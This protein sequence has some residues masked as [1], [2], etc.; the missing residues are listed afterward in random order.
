MLRQVDIELKNNGLQPE[1]LLEKKIIQVYETMNVRFGMVLV[2][3]SGSG[4][5]TSIM[6]LKAALTSLKDQ[7]FEHP[8]YEHVSIDIINPKCITMGELYGENN[9]LTQVWIDGLASTIMRRNA[10]D[11]SLDKKWLVF[12]GPI[13]ALWIENMNTVLDD[14]MTLCLANGER[15]RLKPQMRM[16]FEVGDLDAASPATVSRLGVVYVSTE[17]VGWRPYV[18][19]WLNR[20]FKEITDKEKERI[21]WNCDTFFP[22]LFQLIRTQLHEP[23]TTQDQNLV[24]SFCALFETVYKPFV[25]VKPGSEDD[26]ERI[27]EEKTTQLNLFIDQ[28]CSYSIL[29]SFGCSIDPE[30]WP[31]FD[32]LYHDLL[33]EEQLDIGYASGLCYDYLLN[34]EKM[35]FKDWNTIVPKFVYS[36][37][38][39]F[40]QLV[41]PTV[42]T[43]RFSYLL[44]E[45]IK[46]GKAVF[47][48]GVTGTGKTVI[49]ESTLDQLKMPIEEGGHLF[50]PIQLTFSARTS[51]YVT[52]NTIENSLQK[53]RKNLLGPTAPSHHAIISIDDI[54]MPAVEKYGAQ[55][56]I[57]LIRQFITYKGF[58]DR[59]QLFWKDIINT[60]LVAAAAPPGGGRNHITQRLT[61][62]FNIFSLPQASIESL[63]LIFS[64]IVNG[65][66]TNFLAEVKGLSNA[67]VNSTIDIYFK[68]IGNLRPTPAKFHYTFNLRDVSK[69]IQGLLMI[70]SKYCS[71]AETMTRL[72]VHESLRVFHDRLISN[73]DKNWFKDNV[74]QLLSRYFHFSTNM[75]D[76][77][78]TNTI[79]FGDYMKIGVDFTEKKYEEITDIGKVTRVFQDY[80]D[81]YNLDNSTQLNLVFF[82]DA[83]D[84]ISRI[85][86]ILRQPRGNAMLV[87]VGGSGKQSLTRLSCF[88][89]GL[90]CYQ[91]EITRGYNLE[92]FRENLKE[93]MVSTGVNGERTVFLFT[94]S[95]IMQETF[96]ED[97]NSILNSGEVP[98][99]FETDEMEK[100]LN[101]MVPVLKA[102]NLPQSRDMCKLKFVERIRDCL[103]V[104]LCMSPVGD[105]LRIRCRQF[106]S[107]INCC[108]ID[109]YLPWPEDALKSVAEH[110]FKEMESIDQ[111]VTPSL[112][113]SCVMVHTSINSISID[114]FNELRRHVYTT[115]KSYLDLISLYQLLLE[116][117]KTELSNKLNILEMGVTKLKD[118][119][120]VVEGLRGEL[121][122]LQPILVEKSKASDEL[123]E[124][125]SKEAGEAEEIKEKVEAETQIVQKQQEEV[126]E[127][128]SRAQEALDV[129]LP[130]L[131]E[132]KRALD[133]LDKKDIAEIKAFKTPPP[134]VQTVMEAV[135]ILLD[136]KADWDSAKKV[137]S[138]TDFIK[139]LQQYDKDNIPAKILQKLHKYIENP[140]MSPDNVK[141]ISFA[142]FSLC[143]W[144]HAISLYA[145]VFKDVEPLRNEVARMNEELKVANDQLAE[146]KDKLSEI[147]G[148][149]EELQRQSDEVNAEKQ[150]ISEDIEITTKRLER[151]E[152][153]TKGLNAEGIRWSEQA[154]DYKEQIRLLIGDVFISSACISYY[155]PFTGIYRDRIVKN[156]IEKLRELKLPLSSDYSIVKTLGDPL[157]IQEWQINGLPTDSVS[158][159]NSLLTTKGKRWPLLID[160]QGQAN[161]WIR[162]NNSKNLT[163]TKLHDQNLLRTLENCIRVGRILLI[164]DIGETLIASLE[165]ILTK[166]IHKQGGRYLIHLGDS[167][168]DY[169]QNFQLFI[170]TKLPNPHYLP[171]VYI[172]VN[173]INFTVT[174]EGLEDQ[175]L[176]L[177]VKKEANEVEEKRTHLVASMADDQKQLNKVQNNILKLLSESKG[178]IL[179]DET[180]INTLAQ[181]QMTAQVISERVAE[182][183]KTEKEINIKRNL[184][185]PVA[186]RGSLLYFV[187]SDLSNI[188]PMYQNSLTYFNRL[189][190]RCLDE[191]EKS[192]DIEKRLSNII[193]YMTK[194]VYTNICR[195][196]FE[197]D[198]LLFSFLICA[199]I[200]RN[201][202]I[203]LDEE[204]FILLRGIVV[205]DRNS[206]LECPILDDITQFQWDML[207]S[208][209]LNLPLFKGLCGH[210]V[211]KWEEWNKWINSDKPEETPLPVPYNET[212][213]PFHLL[214]FLRCFKEERLMF[215]IREYV[216]KQLGKDM[217]ENPSVSMEDIH[218]DMD[219]YTPCIFVLSTGADPTSLL[220]RFAEDM[221]MSNNLFVISLGQGQGPKAEALVESA[222]VK[223][224]W[225]LLQNCHL[226]KSWM[227]DLEKMILT[228]PSKEN[229]HKKFRLFLT[230]MPV[231]YFPVPVLQT[232]VKLTNEPPKGLQSNLQRSYETLINDELLSKSTKPKIWKKL[233][234]GLAFFHGV[235][236]ERRKFGPLGWNILYEFND[237]DLE[238]SV[239]VLY[240]FLEE[241][242]DVPWDALQY[243]VGHI[244]YGGRVTD[245]WDRRCLIS[246][247]D[248]YI[249]PSVLEDDFKLS[250]SGIYYIP[251]ESPHDQYLKYIR[252]LPSNEDPEV[253]GMHFNASITYQKQEITTL[254]NT[255]LS[256]Q[257]RTAKAGGGKTND[258]TVYELATELE[259]IIPEILSVEKASHLTFV[260]DKDTGLMN[261]L[262]T[263]LSQEIVKFNRLISK[264]KTTL[265]DIKKAIQGLIVMS[266]DLDAMYVSFL[267]NQVPEIWHNVAY[268]SL[269]PLGSWVKDLI[270]RV[271][272]M[273]K[274][275][276]Q[277]PPIA[278]PLPAFFFP[279]GFMTGTLQ[280]YSRKYKVPINS[281]D[282]SFKI[283]DN[284]DVNAIHQPPT[285]GVIIYGLWMEGG[286]WDRVKRSLADSVLGELYSVI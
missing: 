94:D 62:H 251:T 61:R 7:G 1:D 97:I 283:Y 75:N 100:I 143:K 127:A 196:L 111:A 204:W 184:Y 123:F 193:D 168:I 27:E 279:Q 237:S 268:P 10:M 42:D 281:L 182:S 270:E 40:F 216:I 83:I 60:S 18:V 3:P 87:G 266:N 72:W 67:I 77:F 34:K 227:P 245:D 284:E 152:K 58:Y 84:H 144:V 158:I 135:N 214:L 102:L 263:V 118:T 222:S 139:L 124:R 181:S 2:G 65:F 59:K 105:S 217:V 38:L 71:R 145:R 254:L 110:F 92:S 208:M 32:S 80:M 125:V 25:F 116:Q 13:D 239:E 157:L 249:N 221:E 280:V 169:D 256:I 122:A 96:L 11:D 228:L 265:S 95:Q 85:L 235:L 45:L 136:E 6:T 225:V 53:I 200:L 198:K 212:A 55:P 82:S 257:P 24:I 233:L 243:V 192:S 43:T 220:L 247:L 215:A 126:A 47:F 226:A 130:A 16:V 258:D 35:E 234:F 231:D 201:R 20:A 68:M 131:E 205:F 89:S 93:L 188:D 277:G 206:Q 21:L 244:N 274:W 99:L 187:I 51:S 19:T 120:D 178:N 163:V 17:T 171:E 86:R 119:N 232:G 183:Q 4:K 202:N 112:V 44:T 74:I 273:R 269:K 101:D 275:I 166:Q 191:S 160:P 41:V 148:R 91:I 64:N 153:L 159:N 264:V 209:Q 103:H 56:P 9:E 104:V 219:P 179:D 272:F 155:G 63:T 57:E 229:I 79:I 246:I 66:L 151:A 146:K 190:N 238:T 252:T 115:P 128:Q 286:R 141:K 36:P 185:R 260:I 261:S 76:L 154:K 23:I 142:A 107:L 165:P 78:G 8:S 73:E 132:A 147:E 49:M 12:D 276:N 170:T 134:A 172:K 48:T 15:I 5:S 46:I 30:E 271:E 29:W 164:E 259:E 248:Q 54:N 174:L 109:W 177:A 161:R 285:D 52:Q 98:N 90:N 50:F 138:R 199:S 278:F 224:D 149:V 28:M 117:K 195:G 240:L 167:D 69:I 186:L 255:I 282:F 262:S 22:S 176:G 241:Q 213:T 140:V 150:K 108:T 267:A 33:E 121:T 236:Q 223:G 81:Q 156:W 88:I 211:D 230:S 114:F 129:A 218:D 162:N 189:I 173:I 26:E 197:K 137:L 70:E 242:K 203:I 180:L 253:F 207:Y 113:E 39:P 210:V 37:D 194:L 31:I 106:P 250:K 175:L 14:N 133:A